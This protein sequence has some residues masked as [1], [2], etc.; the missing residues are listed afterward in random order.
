MTRNWGLVWAMVLLLAGGGCGKYVAVRGTVTLDGQPLEG[1]TVTFIPQDGAESRY[2]PAASTEADGSFSLSTI[3]KQGALAGKYK[4][5]LSKIERRSKRRGSAPAVT[6][7][8]EKSAAF[9]SGELLPVKYTKFA[10]SPFSIEVP[11]GG[12]TDLV[13]SLAS[14][15]TTK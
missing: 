12:M 11:P 7:D 15:P 1:V 8:K 3:N 13:L 2:S 9:S 4:V 5:V 6:D 14:G 10:T